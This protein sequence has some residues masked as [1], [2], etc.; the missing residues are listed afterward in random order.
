MEAPSKCVVCNK[1]V[2]RRQHALMCDACD[3]WQ[4]RLCRTGINQTDYRKMVRGELVMDFFCADCPG[5][6]PRAPEVPAPRQ[7]IVPHQEDTSFTE[8]MVAIVDRAR[9]TSSLSS[10][11]E[12]HNNS[13]FSAATPSD[14]NDSA[15][16]MSSLESVPNDHNTSS[17]TSQPNNN[18]ALSST[19]TSANPSDHNDSATAALSTTVLLSSPESAPVHNLT[20]TFS[21]P[22]HSNDALTSTFT[23]PAKSNEA[24]STSLI[25]SSD[26]SASAGYQINAT[27][28]SPSHHNENG[29]CALTTS[30]IRSID[31][32]HTSPDD[33]N[34]STFTTPSRPNENGNFTIITSF[35][36]SIDTSHISPN[37]HNTTTIITSEPTPIGN[38]TVLLSE[39]AMDEAMDDMDE[40]MDV[41]DV[42]QQLNT[43][44]TVI[45]SYE[46][47]HEAPT[48]DDPIVEEEEPMDVV[49]EDVI[50]D[51]GDS[52]RHQG[53]YNRNPG[54][55]P[56]D[57]IHEPAP[58]AIVEDQPITYEIIKGGTVKGGDLLADNQ[59]YTYSLSRRRP[60]VTT[61]TCSNRGK[62]C[63][64]TV[65]QIGSTFQPG[66]RSHNHTSNP[67]KTHY[68]RARAVVS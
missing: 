19:F 28:T 64:A 42:Q 31:T 57:S 22:S 24:L 15:T 3:R 51:Q 36:S 63:A 41:D 34:Y 61:W 16:I 38:S 40:A 11:S 30:V 50:V 12:G 35:L 53:P 14:Q 8:S 45:P 66:G 33:H 58:Q 5:P 67:D 46:P 44:Y 20:S 29:S 21:S 10:Q 25:S 27:V 60:R 49:P 4:H 43:T 52:F 56:E 18:E 54:P 6:A 2:T 47:E 32:S 26:T 7:A 17:F 68:A 65:R 62:K 39:E 9:D 55:D 37:V 59:G 48:P 13:T 1:T 23:S